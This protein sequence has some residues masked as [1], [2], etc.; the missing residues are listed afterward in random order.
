MG[1]ADGLAEI[2]A[3]S[4]LFM[5]AAVCQRDAHIRERSA[6]EHAGMR[7]FKDMGADQALELQG[8]RVGGHDAIKRKAAATRRGCKLKMHLGIMAQR[9]KMAI[10]AYRLCD[11]FAV[12]DAAGAKGNGEPKPPG[13]LG[14]P[15]PPAEFCP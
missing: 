15:R 2:A 14:G 12:H 11:G 1:A 3:L 9:L 7:R 5:R 4:M 10:A 8:E 13:H 6:C